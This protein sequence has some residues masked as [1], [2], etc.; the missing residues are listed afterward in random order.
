MKVKELKKYGYRL[1]VNAEGRGVYVLPAAEVSDH[2][3][4]AISK[5]QL[6]EITRRGITAAQKSLA[7]LEADCAPNQPS[8][9]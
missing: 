5:P 3:A 6:A 8:A 2:A 4:P 7:R 1:V 9:A